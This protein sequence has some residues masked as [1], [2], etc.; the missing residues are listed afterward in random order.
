M[1]LIFVSGK[2]VE[3]VTTKLVM[4]EEKAVDALVASAS[5]EENLQALSNEYVIF[6]PANGQINTS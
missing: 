3:E 5:L 6:Y 4:Q 2:N 1:S